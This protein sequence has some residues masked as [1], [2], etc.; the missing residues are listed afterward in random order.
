MDAKG[1][2][3]T[4]PLKHVGTKKAAEDIG[5]RNIHKLFINQK[6][7]IE[8]PDGVHE[9]YTSL[10]NELYKQGKI[11]LEELNKFRDRI[12]NGNEE[13]RKLM[14]SKN[15]DGTRYVNQ[16]ED[17]GSVSRSFVKP[18]QVKKVDAITRDDQG[19]IIPIS[20]RDDFNNEDFRYS[21][22]I[23]LIGISTISGLTHE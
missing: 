14:L 23:P 9:G 11:S 19:N 12:S 2:Y 18:S 21:W 7:S 6:N 4:E 17:I 1:E 10:A 15:I 3:T 16:G 13:I 20:K 5:G 22:I 8:T